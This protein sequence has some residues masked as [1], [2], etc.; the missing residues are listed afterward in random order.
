[1]STI[2]LPGE[3]VKRLQCRPVNA[4]PL[5]QEIWERQS[6]KKLPIPRLIDMYNHHINGVNCADQIRSYYRFKRR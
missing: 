5:I 2:G 6:T 4:R 1:M 3:T